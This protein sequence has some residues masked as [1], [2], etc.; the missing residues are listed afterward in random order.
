[1]VKK[2][3]IED[4]DKVVIFN[5]DGGVVMTDVDYI[6]N[7]KHELEPAAAALTD[8]VLS[9]PSTAVVLTVVTAP[10]E[11]GETVLYSFKTQDNK[12]LYVDSSDV[13][14]VDAAGDN[15]LFV[16]EDATDGY[17]IRCNT[18]AFNG[19][20]Q[21]LQYYHEYFTVYG[22]N[23]SNPGRYLMN[24]YAEEQT[25][26]EDGFYLIGPDWTV[27]A[28][29]PANAF[30]EN[31]EVGGEMLLAATLTEGDQIKVVKV[32]NGAIT[33]WYPDGID[34]QYTVDAAHAGDV[35]IYFRETY[36][37]DW[38]AFGGYFYIAADYKI[39]CVQGEH[40]LISTAASRAS[41][42]TT[43]TVYVEA[44]EDYELDT[45]TVLCG[46]TEIAVSKVNDEMY[47]FVMPAGDVTVT[48]TFAI[49]AT[50]PFF[51]TQSITLDGLIGVNFNMELP[52]ISGVDYTT[53][54]MTFSVA[55]GECTERVDYSASRERSSQVRG[56]ACYVNAVQMAE[57]ITA[58][59][60][61]TQ[62]GTE[63]TVEK[64]YSVMDYIAAYEENKDK[65]D[66]TS[67]ALVE[68]LADY[69]HHVQIFLSEQ[70]GWTLG[71]DYAEM[72]AVYT[73]NYSAETVNS[74]KTAVEAYAL[75]KT[76]NADTEKIT[77]SLILDSAIEIR[78]FFKMTSGYSGS[79]EAGA[80]YTATK[81][82]ERYQVSVLNIPA[83]QLSNMYTVSVTTDAGAAGITV[84]A[85][86]YVRSLLNAYTSTSAQN[87]A[88]AIYAYS[89]A[90]DAYKAAH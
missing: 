24:F 3:T 37:N 23:A 33:A 38:A 13:K 89:Q 86:S 29:N 78:V 59:F 14:F 73:Q 44:E 67:C 66:E 41:A 69:G 36:N 83:H 32:E 82:G 61:Y 75:T 60:H 6:Y 42:G 25:A 70:R 54:Y 74:V 17:Y 50:E 85:L 9:V 2:T 27:G 7:S 30:G 1:M 71:T 52:E 87:A 76:L 49:P 55:H 19:N 20:A 10:S 34:T 79:F 63:K 5:P 4:G 15:T 8:E 68:A 12:Y 62:N 65:F 48:A 16:L 81:V 31:M 43:V 90:A 39:T 35:T 47:T 11:D 18:A 26:I 57:P 40:G 88:A 22:M 28:I 77:Y 72:T 51:K 64:T 58:T 21:Y 80:P 46:E 53:S 56:F 84:S 45:L